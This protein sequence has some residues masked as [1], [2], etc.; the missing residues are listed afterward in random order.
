[1]VKRLAA[2][3]VMMVVAASARRDLNGLMKR[4]THTTP[5]NAAL[6]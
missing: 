6:W 2:V 4:A 5:R 3:V 1:M